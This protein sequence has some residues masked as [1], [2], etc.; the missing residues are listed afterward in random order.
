M[1]SLLIHVWIE[2]EILW[3]GCNGPVLT[4]DRV[5]ANDQDFT[6]YNLVHIYY[7]LSS[8]VSESNLSGIWARAQPVTA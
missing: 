3:Q 6:P 7:S 2:I 4:I 8:S 5:I 1:Q